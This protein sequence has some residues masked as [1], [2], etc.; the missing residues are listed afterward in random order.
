MSNMSYC[1]FENTATDLDDCVEALTDAPD[2]REF[3]LALSKS[4]LAG[5]RKLHGLACTLVATDDLE[6]ALEE[7]RSRKRTG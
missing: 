7:A 3:V 5:L 2:V 1:R 6:D 4:E